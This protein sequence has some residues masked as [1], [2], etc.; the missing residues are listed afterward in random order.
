[1]RGA[2]VAGAAWI[3]LVL[4]GCS[5]RNPAFQGPTG[6]GGAPSHA[7]LDADAW[8]GAVDGAPP[9]V[10]GGAPG[11]PV[12]AGI[13]LPVPADAPP[14]SGARV[15][16]SL[17]GYWSMDDGSG[18]TVRDD[19]GNGNHGTL[20]GGRSSGWAAG[21]LNGALRFD[22]S[23][24]VSVPSS[25][26]LRAVGPLTIAAWVSGMTALDWT[27]VIACPTGTFEQRYALGFHDRA[28]A[29]ESIDRALIDTQLYTDGRWMHIAVTSDGRVTILYVNGIERIRETISSRIDGACPALTIG[30]RP[31][32]TPN[33][34]A[35]TF[36]GLIDEL[37]L[38]ARVLTPSE[39]ATLAR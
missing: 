3:G 16:G 31:D 23:A 19:S 35:Y 11:S 29:F 14:L 33:A 15:T 2:V 26:T 32:D 30:G 8:I 39:I 25:S 27:Y 21:K 18:T 24:V 17:L 7:A 4:F 9:G 36:I 6:V 13:P 34:Y 12:D 1:M 38:Y 28:P 22:G 10:V 20:T 5:E 37:Y